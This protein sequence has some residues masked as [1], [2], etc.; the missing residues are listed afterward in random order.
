M[1]RLLTK[2]EKIRKNNFFNHSKNYLIA[3][4]FNKALAFITIPI[5]TRLLLPE[6]YGILAIFSSIIS[7]FTILMGMNFH[8][9]INRKYYE[10]DNEFY[11]FLG[12]NIIFIL[13]VN[14]IFISVCFILRNSLSSFFSIDSKLFFTA[15]IISSFSFFIQM[16]LTY[17]QASQQSKKY[18]RI[19]I[20]RNIF[21]TIVA[22]IWVYLLNESKYL[23][24][25]YAQLIVIGII[26][27]FVIY[28]LIKISEF[29]WKNEHIKYSL[30][31]GIPLIPHALSGFILAQFDRVI[32]NQISGSYETGLYS[33]AYNVGMIM[34]VFVL[35]INKSWVP[36]FYEN[37]KNNTYRK[38]Q[39]LAEK[40]SEIVFLV[41]LGLIFFSKEIILI[42]ADEKYFKALEIV[43][44]IIFSAIAK[45]WYTLFA[46]YAF[47][48][49]KTSLI[50][51]FTF[52]AGFIN[53]CLNYL[54]IPK[55]GYISAAWTTLVSY[56]I[57]FLLHYIN[58]K[59]ILKIEIIKIYNMLKQLICFVIV[60]FIFEFIKVYL[61]NIFYNMFFKI[62]FL[63]IF[64]IILKLIKRGEK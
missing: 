54:F 16:E 17:L 59:W 30:Y 56:I 8:G 39:I 11:S 41:A 9:A 36:V 43:P 15:I 31:F 21:I 35:A 52:F 29:K 26:S 58:V 25:I 61:N 2:I 51:L 20:I 19:S 14:I 10:K 48:N 24:K 34:N 32:I 5:F 47:Y 55:Y 50:S 63:I 1:Q 23:G 37:L 4:F 27:C 53:V 64:Y 13:I 7:I 44:I 3:D 22:I 33:F 28:K 62:L 49:K 42:M 38:I 60:V 46:N 18:A 40:S 6:E 45:Y 57:L 12:S